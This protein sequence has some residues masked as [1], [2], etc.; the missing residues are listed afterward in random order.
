MVHEGADLTPP[1]VG[2][3]TLPPLYTSCI[4]P[5][6]NPYTTRL[7]GPPQSTGCIR[8]VYELH[9]TPQATPT[10]CELY[11]ANIANLSTFVYEL[12][13]SCIRVVWR[14]QLVYNALH[15]TRIQRV[16][17]SPARPDGLYTSC[18]RVVYE[19]YTSCILVVSVPPSS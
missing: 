2:T 17:H 5:V 1:P 19:L 18:I 13:T 7:P 15:T 6:Y 10:W 14:I 4:Q 11:A 3:P 9:T 16:P 12:Y 8:V